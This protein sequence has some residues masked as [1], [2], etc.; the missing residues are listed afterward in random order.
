MIIPANPNDAAGM[1]SQALA[2]FKGVSKTGE[3]LVLKRPV[4]CIRTK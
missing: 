3:V 4:F 2:V 1:V